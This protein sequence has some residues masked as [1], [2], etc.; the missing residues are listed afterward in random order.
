MF[1]DDESTFTRNHHAAN[2]YER[3][4]HG[5]EYRHIVSHQPSLMVR[6]CMEANGIGRLDLFSGIMSG[7][8]Y[9]DV[10][11]KKMLPT[12]RSLLSDDN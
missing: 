8:K 9:I 12:A 10:L 11:K 1:N 2:N 7:T 6:G 3:R 5:D 4:R